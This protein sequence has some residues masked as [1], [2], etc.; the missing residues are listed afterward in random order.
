MN[1]SVLKNTLQQTLDGK[2]NF[3]QVVGTLLNEGL[4]SYHVDLIRSEYRYYN[5]QGESYVELIHTEMH[6]PNKTFSVDEVKA[7]IKASQAGQIKYKEFI[8]RVLNAGCVY[9]ITYLTGKKVVYFGR[10]G[11]SHTEHFPK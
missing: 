7:A 8:D 1:I 3:P 6:N 9:Y 2:I 5:P 11:E 10:N 4:E